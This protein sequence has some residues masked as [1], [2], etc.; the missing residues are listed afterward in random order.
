[1]FT[2]SSIEG[3]IVGELFVHRS[4][5]FTTVSASCLLIADSHLSSKSSSYCL[6]VSTR[7]AYIIASINEHLKLQ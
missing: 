5:T 7:Q 6:L 1:M 4:A 2:T 3:L